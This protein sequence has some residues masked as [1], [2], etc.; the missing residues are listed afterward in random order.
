MKPVR[1]IRGLIA[2]LV[3]WMAWP[4]LAQADPPKQLHCV[5]HAF[6]PYIVFERGKVSGIEADIMRLVSK[7][8]GLPIKIEVIPWARA[9]E[10]ARLGKVDCFFAAFKNPEREAF[11]HFTDTPIHTSKL[12]FYKNAKDPFE[13]TS[14]Q[15]L[16]GKSIAVVR[17]FINPPMIEDLHQRGLIQ[18]SE[19]AELPTCFSMLNRQRID[20]VLINELV[21]RT[22]QNKNVVALSPSVSETPA[23]VTVPKS[24]PHP[25]VFPALNTAMTAVLESD[26]YARLLQRHGLSP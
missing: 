6:A 15:A 17:G 5:T 14:P 11:L 7:R 24:G 25:H 18:L 13:Y 10:E 23:Y 3:Y 22:I 2:I 4:W 16:H 9:L 12:V 1:R 19:V 20:L 21:G 26:E 8:M